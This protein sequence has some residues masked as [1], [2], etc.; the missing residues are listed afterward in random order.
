MLHNGVISADLI[1]RILGGIQAKVEFDNGYG[2]SVV[3]GFGTYGAEDGLYELA[4]TKN[5]R[6]CYDT[7]ITDDVLGYLS[8]EDV[9][10]YMRMV[11]KLTC[12][13]VENKE[14]KQLQQ[15]TG[16]ICSPAAH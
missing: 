4:V 5:G 11:R 14:L 16:N 9:E 10:R 13:E 15:P 7:P 2:V 3:R 1:N 8:P 6:L 12:A